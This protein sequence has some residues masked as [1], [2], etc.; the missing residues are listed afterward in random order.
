MKPETEIRER[1]DELNERQRGFSERTRMSVDGLML[2][3]R[4][5]E[6]KWVLES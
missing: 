3:M 2:T 6:L 5:S 1:I 4:I